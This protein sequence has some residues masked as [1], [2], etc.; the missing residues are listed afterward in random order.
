M[1]LR[2]RRLARAPVR[3]PND[4]TRYDAKHR[5]S[6][7]LRHVRQFIRQTRRGNTQCSL[8]ADRRIW[9]RRGCDMKVSASTGVAVPGNALP[10]ICDISVTNGCN[11]ACDFCGFARDKKLVGP[12]RYLD[13]EAFARALPI[14]RRRHIKY[15]TF[16]GGE[17]L[18]HPDIVE[19]VAS[20]T[21][22]GMVCRP[23]IE[24][25]VSHAPYRCACA[26]RAPAPA[27]VDR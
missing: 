14:L 8:M 9:T 15:V 7:S 4:R 2:S 6:Q 25:L 22:A 18:L 19:L 5:A 3:T 17:P 13:R 26:C 21:Q 23:H 24:R 20:A 27:R 10:A 12:R 16:Q 11:A 1:G